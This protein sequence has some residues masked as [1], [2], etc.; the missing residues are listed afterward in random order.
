VPSKSKF[1]SDAFEAIYTAAEDLRRAGTIDRTTMQSF[2]ASCLQL[3]E[4][5]AQNND[6]LASAE[7]CHGEVNPPCGPRLTARCVQSAARPCP[8]AP[9]N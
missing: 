4:E 1:K 9:P 8:R 3:P 7:I 5:I 2:D 6:G